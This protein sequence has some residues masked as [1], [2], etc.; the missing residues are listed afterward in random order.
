MAY[1]VGSIARCLLQQFTQSPDLGVRVRQQSRHL[2]LQGARA[3][4]L[5]ERGVRRQRQ[6]ISR[7]VKGASPQSSF[8]G[9]LLHFIR[10]RRQLPQIPKHLVGEVTIFGEEQVNSLAV[11]GTRANIP[12]KI[13]NK[14]STLLEVLIAG[15][16]FLSVP[17]GLVDGYCRGKNR[18]TLDRKCEVG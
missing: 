17:A 2:R 13:G 14:V 5:S 15:G 10:P 6:Q 18:Q 11:E 12:A 4:D 9:L 16:T 8:V 1:V 3:D 7:K